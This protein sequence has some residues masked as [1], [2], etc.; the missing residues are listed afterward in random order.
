MAKRKKSIWLSF[1]FGLKGNYASL[2][3][4]LD[5][6]KAIDC[7]NGLAYFVYDN[8]NMLPVEELV[9]HLKSELERLVQ[10]T[11][12][13]RIYVIYRDDEKGSVK[14]NFLFGNRKTPAWNGYSDIANELNEDEAF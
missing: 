11:N 1:D 12:N 10:P 14:G 9:T 2:F 6:N 8:E 3:T 4:F 7:G 5:N 13:D